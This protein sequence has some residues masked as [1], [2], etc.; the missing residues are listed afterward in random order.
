MCWLVGVVGQWPQ[1]VPLTRAIWWRI[2]REQEKENT[3]I[4]RV[5]PAVGGWR[6]V[7][8]VTWKRAEGAMYTKAELKF[9]T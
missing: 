8:M 7:V 4:S 5:F 6:L 1:A 2:V 9:V 3:Y